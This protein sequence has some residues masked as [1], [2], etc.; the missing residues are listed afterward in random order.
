MDCRAASCVGAV[1][2]VVKDGACGSG[3]VC[4]GGGNVGAL[5]G[6]QN[7]MT[8]G[9]RGVVVSFCFLC[10][11]SCMDCRAASC[12][13]AVCTVVKDGACGSGG[14][15]LGGRNGGALSDL[16]NGMTA[17]AL[18]VVVSF[19]FAWVAGFAE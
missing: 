2:T 10:V 14:V 8:A 18:V 7:G 6:L 1:C 11:G 13:G 15:C 16:Q 12:V 3:G 4:L 17:G 9:A 5:S 19:C